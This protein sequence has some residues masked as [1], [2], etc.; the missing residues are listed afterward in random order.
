MNVALWKAAAD[1]P[2]IQMSTGQCGTKGFERAAGTSEGVG[3]AWRGKS[4]ARFRLAHMPELRAPGGSERRAYDEQ[5]A[6]AA[7]SPIKQ[8]L[9][10]TILPR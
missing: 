1:P 4:K 9:T 8:Q 3:M 6:T 5:D 10:A 7:L 2:Q